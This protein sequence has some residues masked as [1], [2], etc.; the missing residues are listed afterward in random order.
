MPKMIG[1]RSGMGTKYGADKADP[2]A[3]GRLKSG[4]EAQGKGKG[5]KKPT[6]GKGKFPLNLKGL[7]GKK[8]GGKK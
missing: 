5:K 8:K 3:V 4:A 6:K 7:F 1:M 2:G